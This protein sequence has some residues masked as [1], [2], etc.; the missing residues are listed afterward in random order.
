VAKEVVRLLGELPGEAGYSELLTM[1]ARDIHRD[2][3]VAL[4]RAFWDH[5]EQEETWPILERAARSPDP[6]TAA[7]VVYIPADRLSPKAQRH[8]AALIAQLLAY[9]DPK[10]RL[11]TLQRV[12]QIP[13]TDTEQALVSPLLTAFESSLP[14][15][16]MA[17]AEAIFTTY[18]GRE[19]ALVCK[20]IEHFRGNRRAII[21][22]SQVLQK[23][24]W[25]SRSQML[26][27]VRAVLTALRADPLTAAV[28]ANLAIIAL[29]WEEVLVILSDLAASNALHGEALMTAVQAIQSAARRPDAAGL[30]LLEEPLRQRADERLR[31]LGLASLVALAEPPRGWD[32]A[33]LA[34]L[35]AYRADSSALVAAAAQFTLPVE[36][37]NPI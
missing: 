36:E 23:T 29:P 12:A 4:L 9:P 2:V 35:N 14:D 10:V 3:R 27:T 5:L 26:P 33:R 7:G 16:L 32:Q 8:L 37:I 13:L 25:K 21:T 15:E 6:A 24:I 11:D 22:A 18:V 17:A 31:R 1:E 28:Q 20:S 30:T 19:A 34:L